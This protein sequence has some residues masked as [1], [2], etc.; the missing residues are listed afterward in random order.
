MLPYEPFRAGARGR[1]HPA[2]KGIEALT[3]V[4]RREE[5]PQGKETTVDGTVEVPAGMV[6]APV[7]LMTWL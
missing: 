7:S 1:G 2:R 3:A 5:T 6:D 4:R